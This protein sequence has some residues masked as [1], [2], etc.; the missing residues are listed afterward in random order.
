MRNKRFA[1]LAMAAIMAASSAMPVMA[2]DAAVEI[3]TNDETSENQGGGARRNTYN[4]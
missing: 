2:D 3:E 4:W 1:V